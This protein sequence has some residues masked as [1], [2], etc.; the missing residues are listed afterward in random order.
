MRL[1]GSCKSSRRKAVEKE[2]KLHIDEMG[3]V[4]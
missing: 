2:L 1:A 4:H 3:V